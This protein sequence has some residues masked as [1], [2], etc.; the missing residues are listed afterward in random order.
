MGLLSADEE[1][2]LSLSPAPQS[3][4][5]EDEAVETVGKPRSPLKDLASGT[6]NLVNTIIGGGLLALPFA[7]MSCGLLLGMALLV[8]FFFI[9]AYTGRLIVKCAMPPI[10]GGLTY[11][12]LAHSAFGK[13]GEVAVEVVIVLFALGTLV[14][15]LGM[16]VWCQ[17]GSLSFFGVTRLI[18]FFLQ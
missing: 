17:N 11:A 7:V 16:P 4:D 6:L 10:S 13:K 14:G 15:Y 8:V 5:S 2:P 3:R 1:T 18:P 9:S 12:S